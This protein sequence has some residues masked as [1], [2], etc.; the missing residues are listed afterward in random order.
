MALSAYLQRTEALLQNPS[1]PSSLY[2]PALLTGYVNEAR[3]QEQ[4]RNGGEGE[5]RPSRY[6][7]LDD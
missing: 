4:S 3:F 7:K 1:A 6:A 5:G 2:D